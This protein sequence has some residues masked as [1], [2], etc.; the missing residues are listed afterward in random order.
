MLSDP[1]SVSASNSDTDTDS[2]FHT[3]S[4]SVSD[5]DTESEVLISSPLAPG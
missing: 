3:V 1:G 4:G 5:P 2:A